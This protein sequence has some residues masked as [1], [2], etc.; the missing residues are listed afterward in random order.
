MAEIKAVTEEERLAREGLQWKEAFF[1]KGNFVR[2]V[3]AFV[4]FLLQAWSGQNCAVP[5]CPRFL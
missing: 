3:I 4:I 5:I 2:F 1:G